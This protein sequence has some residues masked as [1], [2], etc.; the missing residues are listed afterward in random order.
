[1][2]WFGSIF[3]MIIS[4]Q[5]HAYIYE[6]KILKT[7]SPA[8]Q[9]PHYVIGLSDFHDK[10]HGI[11]KNQQ[12]DIDRFLLGCNRNDLLVVTEDLSS[13]GAGGRSRCGN[14]CID[15]RG[16]IL[17]GLAKK[18][19]QLSVPVE[20]VEYRYCRVAAFGPIF[21][22]IQHNM[23]TF[24]SATEITV[25]SLMQ[26]IGAVMKEIQAFKD[27]RYLSKV[28]KESL[29]R[30][31]VQLKQLSVEHGQQACVADILDSCTTVKKR[32]EYLKH[33]LTFDS[34]LLD[35]KMLHAVVNAKQ[36]RVILA[37]AGGAHISK[38][39]QVLQDMG[40]EMVHQKAASFAQS[41]D[42]VHY[43][44]E[45]RDGSDRVQVRPEPVNLNFLQQ[46]IGK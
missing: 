21:N 24:P 44:V 20:N 19:K 23:Y 6:I 27:G 32:L 5:M 14:F 33:W 12:A 3:F 18:C 34:E 43:S 41:D 25:A 22:N 36:A 9:L 45:L 31:H 15:S 39:S 2:K 4:S 28:Y 17:G 10:Q 35:L 29:G 1:M 13:P 11:I 40:Y 26:E 46:F 30:M 42:A 37:V 7:V 16:G 38:M 8:T